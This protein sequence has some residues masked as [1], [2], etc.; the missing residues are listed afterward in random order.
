MKIKK[1]MFGLPVKIGVSEEKY[2][3]VLPK[4]PSNKYPDLKMDLVSICLN[5]TASQ[6][7]T[8]L[9]IE[10][11]SKMEKPMCVLTNNIQYL[12]PVIE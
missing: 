7:V 2:L 5:K 6:Y 9:S 10:C 3:Q 4:D 1:V 12:E 8:M 11:P